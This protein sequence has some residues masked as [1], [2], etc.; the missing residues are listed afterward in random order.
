MHD[1]DVPFNNRVRKWGAGGRG[2]KRS[3]APK[4]APP[5]AVPGAEPGAGWTTWARG[6]ISYLPNSL[7]CFIQQQHRLKGDAWGMH[8]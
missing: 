2:S 5:V 1:R 8:T 3:E 7:T 4:I 6:D